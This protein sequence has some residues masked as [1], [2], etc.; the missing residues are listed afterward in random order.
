MNVNG[1]QHPQASARHLCQHGHGQKILKRLVRMVEKV[2]K[3][4]E[5]GLKE[6]YKEKQELTKEILLEQREQLTHGGMQDQEA[7][8]HL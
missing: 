6:A 1:A 3:K 8:H 4:G 5:S 7:S 2:G